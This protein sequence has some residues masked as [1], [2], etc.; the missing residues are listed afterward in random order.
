MVIKY[1]SGNG[2][3]SI[4]DATASPCTPPESADLET[5]SGNQDRGRKCTF[6]NCSRFKCL[7]V[8]VNDD[9]KIGM[10]LFVIK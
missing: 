5:T 7:I 2:S 4:Q 3:S 8:I 1:D 10:V 9:K 6:K